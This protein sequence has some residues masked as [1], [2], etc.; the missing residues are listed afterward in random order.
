MDVMESAAPGM[1]GSASGYVRPGRAP[2][3]V[4]DDFVARAAV[5]T[6]RELRRHYGIGA[7]LL[8]KWLV[9][10]GLLQASQPNSNYRQMPADF[11]ARARE[12]NADLREAYG[13][14]DAL[15]ARWRRQC[16]IAP[17]QPRQS[18]VP[19]DFADHAQ[20]TAR[21]LSERYGVCKNTITD[22]RKKIGVVWRPP[23][24]A[25]RFRVAPLP[26]LPPAGRDM[27]IMGRAAD[28]LRTPRGGGWIVY[29]CTEAGQADRDG[30][31]FFVGTRVMTED[32]MLQMA[33][34]KGFRAFEDMPRLAPAITSAA[35]SL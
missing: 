16:G 24:S 1:P 35:V 12:R 10:T 4:P 6:R 18:P 30:D 7:Q 21:E 34:R 13:C 22:W 2:R 20:L 3:P 23:A 27:S 11:P 8:G 31:H 15:I 26:I 33:E 29:R 19:D 17:L 5:L 14:G 9:A 32:D 28:H 25:K